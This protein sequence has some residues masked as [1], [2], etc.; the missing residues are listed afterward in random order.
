M[1]SSSI[2]DQPPCLMNWCLS[3]SVILFSKS[4]A[5]ACNFFQSVFLLLSLI[6]FLISSKVISP[7]PKS[8]ITSGPDFCYLFLRT[9]IVY[10]AASW[11]TREVP[12][13]MLL[14]LYLIRKLLRNLPWQVSLFPG[15]PSGLPPSLS[16]S[17]FLWWRASFQSLYRKSPKVH[18]ALMNELRGE[19][20]RCLIVFTPF[21]E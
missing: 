13:A 14:C 7:A 12:F 17:L 9:S 2:I 5:S 19:E 1:E 21:R 10:I 3:V 4:I 6:S 16:C 8:S 20:G 15:K 18:D 11:Q